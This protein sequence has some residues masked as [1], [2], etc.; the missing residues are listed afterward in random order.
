VAIV[1]RR[2]ENSNAKRKTQNEKRIRVFLRTDSIT[3]FL[4]KS[5]RSTESHRVLGI[6][7]RTGVIVL[8]PL[9][10]KS[11]VGKA[12]LPVSDSLSRDGRPFRRSDRR[13]DQ[14]RCASHQIRQPQAKWDAHARKMVDNSCR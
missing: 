3:A 11:R 1:L 5:L 10:G 14:I 12:S 8:Q 2:T 6:D 13:G 9:N 7:V 4:F